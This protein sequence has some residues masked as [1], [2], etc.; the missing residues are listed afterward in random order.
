MNKEYQLINFVQIRL[1]QQKNRFLVS[2]PVRFKSP[3]LL[4]LVTLKMGPFFIRRLTDF[5]GS[6]V[7]TPPPLS[8]SIKYGLKILLK[9]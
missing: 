9:L 5:T 3:F 6:R 4:T 7:L 8:L 1:E 2:L